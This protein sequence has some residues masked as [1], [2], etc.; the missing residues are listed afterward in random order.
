MYA[1]RLSPG[2]KGI[3]T[4][5]SL[6]WPNIAI[7]RSS[8]SAGCLRSPTDRVGRVGLHGRAQAGPLAI[9]LFPPARSPYVDQLHASDSATGRS[10]WQLSVA[11]KMPQNEWLSLDAGYGWCPR[12]DCA[13]IVGGIGSRGRADTLLLP[14]S[15]RALSLAGKSSV[16]LRL[17][18][19]QSRA[20]LG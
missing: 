17:P 12:L 1:R 14:C 20:A 15:I 13:R 2:R 9:F 19:S 4:S 11:A 16:L 3:A 6:R 10:F 18:I 5:L 7:P 8:S